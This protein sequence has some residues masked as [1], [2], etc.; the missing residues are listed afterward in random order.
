MTAKV[1]VLPSGHEFTVEP[2]ESLLDG[3]LRAGLSIHYNCNSGSCGDCRARR[4][5]GELGE[6]RH[7]DFVLSERERADGYFLLCRATAVS[8][9]VL[10]VAEARS[11]ADV[12]QQQ[13]STQVSK[14]VR[15][16]D[17][18][19]EVQVRTPRSK[20]LWFLAGQHVRLGIAGLA[21]RNKSIA[22]C[23]CNGMVLQ[24]HVRRVANDPFSEHVFSKLK[25]RDTVE[26]EGPFGDFVLDETAERPIIFIAF[27][28][29][30]APIKS[31]IEHAISL[32]IAQPIWLYW[33]A[34]QAQD[35]YLANYCRA[36]HDA[37]DA[38]EFI[39]IS[40][41]EADT[42]TAAEVAMVRAAARI[43]ADHPDLRGFDVYVNG[44]DTLFA[45]IS[46]AL[47]AQGLPPER[48]F[49]DR[50]QRF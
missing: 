2:G 24:F 19:M 18:V 28:T 45:E 11:V 15:L 9:L 34:R 23:P 40:G 49:I 13:L 44:P 32:D 29:G 17:D 16:N 20:T 39:E 41:E 33:V 50:V 1:R 27:E 14:L 36:W 12:P 43:C 21:P 8:D 6:T 30:F 22:S 38:F 46:A 10:E 37:L 42:M 5:S 4:L 25:L 3:A 47:L 7:H 31:L 35:H 26:I 48:L